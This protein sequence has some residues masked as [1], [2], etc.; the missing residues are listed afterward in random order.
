MGYD[1]AGLQRLEWLG[2]VRLLQNDGRLSNP[3]VWF[4]NENG[5]DSGLH[6][7]GVYCWSTF[8]NS[9]VRA[10]FHCLGQRAWEQYRTYVELDGT[11]EWMEGQDS[12]GRAVR[13]APIAFF[14]GRDE[15]SG[16]RLR[17]V[18]RMLWRAGRADQFNAMLP[19]VR[20]SHPVE[21]DG[22]WNLVEVTEV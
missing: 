10:R 19:N 7:R 9:F 21:V 15:V 17:A 3:L 1:R 16:A 13:A 11:D 8:R 6:G 14:Q 22:S 12:S 2:L 18:T 20:P 4:Y 5:R